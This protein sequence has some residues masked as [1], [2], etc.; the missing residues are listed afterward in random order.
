M[1]K[2]IQFYARAVGAVIFAFV[3]C[4]AREVDGQNVDVVSPYKGPVAQGVD[5]TTLDGKVLCGYQG[6]FGAPGD[7]SLK[8]GWRHWTK[9][10]GSLADDN[11]KVDLWPDVSELAPA[12]RFSTDF[13]LT[14]GRPAEVFSS[15]KKPTV[16][17]HFQWM[18]D[19]GID[20]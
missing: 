15:Y 18:Q 13:K 16:L 11:A 20:G 6:W 4:A 14:D 19:Y 3:F 1:P 7:G 5:A 12:E 17:R 2:K 10:P 8:S 9:Q